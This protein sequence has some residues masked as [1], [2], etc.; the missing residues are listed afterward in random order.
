[1]EELK[2]QIEEERQQEELQQQAAQSGYAS[3]AGKLNWMYKGEAVGEP[4]ATTGDATAI[5]RTGAQSVTQAEKENDEKRMNE[6]ASL[7]TAQED[8]QGRNT[9]AQSQQPK[10]FMGSSTH[11]KNE[12]WQR[13]HNDPLLAMKQ[14]QQR[15]V[16]QVKSNPVQMQAIKQEINTAQI[17][18]S[19]NDGVNAQTEKNHARES[20]ERRSSL[21]GKKHH[22]RHHSP[23][24][25]S[26][27][28]E[29]EREDAA[30]ERRLH[31]AE[32]H[33]YR[34]NRSSRRNAS[35]RHEDDDRSNSYERR[36]SKQRRTS[37]HARR[38]NRSKS[39]SGSRED[40][41]ERGENNPQQPRFGR[42]DESGVTDSKRESQIARCDHQ[43]RSKSGTRKV[44]KEDD[45]KSDM[46]PRANVQRDTTTAADAAPA[47]GYGLEQRGKAV[48]EDRLRESKLEFERRKQERKQSEQTRQEQ[49]KHPN[50]KRKL[51]DEEKQRR[52]HAMAEDA[53]K[54][55]Q[56]RSKRA[57]QVQADEEHGT[58]AKDLAAGITAPNSGGSLRARMQMA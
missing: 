57:M 2:R 19:E 54:H 49:M 43:S 1:M 18:S 11:D 17:R 5:T 34:R 23:K 15:A 39:R 44:K 8:E 6:P 9:A 47:D 16:Q 45:S 13:L 40:D 52:L 56:I 58:S 33:K 38:R 37:R 28:Y 29:S 12:Q 31:R 32:R 27:D 50:K 14:A 46:G 42:G 25:E 20:R 30:H 26:D 10:L 55:E 48:S 51:S 36:R 7:G 21:H 53:K 3:N 24:E 35:D 41:T 22:R 4:L